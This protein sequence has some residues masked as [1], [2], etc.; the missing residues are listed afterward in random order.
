MDFNIDIKNKIRNMKRCIK[1]NW[2]ISNNDVDILIRAYEKQSKMI[3]L[4]AGEIY[5][6]YNP[7]FKTEEKVIEYYEKEAQKCLK[8]KRI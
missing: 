2:N 1:D 6:A 8:M 5:I 7:R 3:E 4:M